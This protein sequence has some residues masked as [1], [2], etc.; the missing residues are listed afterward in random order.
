VVI[1]LA[2]ML[3]GR[4]WEVDVLSRGYG[5]GGIGAERVIPAAGGAARQFGDEPVMIARRTGVQVWVGE[6]RYGVG[7]VAEAVGA[8]VGTAG[9]PAALRNEGE[10]GSFDRLRTGSSA[11]PQDDNFKVVHLLDDGFQH[12]GLARA[13]DV[14]VV[15][16][17]D[18][19]D[20]LLPAGNRREPLRALGRADV[21]V[22]R[23]EERERVE[24]RVRGLMRK[25]AAMWSVRRELR[26]AEGASA[27]ARAGAMNAVAFC[28]IARPEGFF[29]ML[30][31]AGCELVE[32]VAFGDHHKYGRADIERIS[33]IATER[34]AMGFLTT[35][36]DAVKLTPSM[37]ER[38]EQVGAV[39][40][41]KLEATFVNEAEVVR[42]LEAR[43]A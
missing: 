38:L 14:V 19:E 13:V 5:R 42:E 41:V 33:A 28:A 30:K 23:E 32:T 4:G 8:R 27:V 43:I 7:V 40:V 36:K 20:A 21:V 34:G 37:M 15:T 1:A 2:E 39:V 16:E 9:S 18:L 29:A 17:E 10:A 6:D 24:A 35:E 3:K 22:V 11:S 26:F 31:E 25:D 12:R